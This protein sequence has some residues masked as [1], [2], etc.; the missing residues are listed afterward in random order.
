MHFKKLLVYVL[1]LSN[2]VT[3]TT[4]RDGD[5]AIKEQSFCMLLKLNFYKFKLKCYNF[6][7]LHVIPMVIT[8]KN[9]YHIHKIKLGRNFRI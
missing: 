9:S 4:K 1:G 7:M 5:N 8:K 3:P 6:R 2:F